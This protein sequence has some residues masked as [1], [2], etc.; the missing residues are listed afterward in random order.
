VR[1]AMKKND[2]PPAWERRRPKL[3]VRE[4]QNLCCFAG[5]LQCANG[6]VSEQ[7]AGHKKSPKRGDRGGSRWLSMWKTI[8]E[9]SI[10]SGGYGRYGVIWSS[11]SCR[12][13]Q[14]DGRKLAGVKRRLDGLGGKGPLRG[15]LARV[16]AGRIERL[17][18]AEGYFRAL[19]DRLRA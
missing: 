12:S 13:D 10:A 3:G 19:A 2:L 5:G 15:T 7:Q 1:G 17:L 16:N 11:Q 9:T 6:D 14:L 4:H 8:G 18:E